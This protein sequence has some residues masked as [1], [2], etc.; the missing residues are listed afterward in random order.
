MAGGT[1]SIEYL[2]RIDDQVKIRGFRIELGEIEA[3]LAEHPSVGEAA[4]LAREEADGRQAAGGLVTPRRRI[5]SEE[6]GERES[7]RE[8][9]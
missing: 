9:I 3:R 5:S 8:R 6:S 1:E 7:A 4:V 2:G